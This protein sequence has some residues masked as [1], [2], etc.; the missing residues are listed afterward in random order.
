M[1]K[2]KNNVSLIDEELPQEETNIICF[3]N[4][5]NIFIYPFYVVADFERT[6]SPVNIV[7]GKTT[8]YQKHKPNSYGLNFNCIY[9]EFTKPINIFNNVNPDSVRK[10][11]IK[12]IEDYQLTQQ[13]KKLH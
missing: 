13:N 6:L 7:N 1:A 4:H 9:E 10:L 5:N 11:L 12:G 8:K 2:C 3:K